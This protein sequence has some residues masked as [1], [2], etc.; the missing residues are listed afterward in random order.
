M[1]NGHQR[2]PDGPGLGV[3]VDEEAVE[4]FRVPQEVLD[5]HASRGELFIHPKPRLINAVVYPDGTCIYMDGLSAPGTYVEGVRTEILDDD[6]GSKEWARA[7]RA[8]AAGRA[9]GQPL[10]G[11]K[12]RGWKEGICSSTDARGK[13]KHGG[14][15]LRQA[16]ILEES[17]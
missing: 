16:G 1:V 17:G 10:G 5:G 3:E 12:R 7:A 8:G 6:D 11:V 2:V 15:S 13:P 14:V 9:G 4:R